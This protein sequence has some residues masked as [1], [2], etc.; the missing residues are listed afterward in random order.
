MKIVVLISF[1]LIFSSCYNANSIDNVEELNLQLSKLPGSYDAPFYL[2]LTVPEHDVIIY[3]TDN[4]DIPD[5]TST[6]YN[7]GIL[8]DSDILLKII[9]YYGK[10]QS[11][12]ITLSYS[13]TT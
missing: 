6:K 3:Y 7:D 13:V 4:G 5:K 9:I 2:I 8:I 10:S 12:V 1:L 11:K